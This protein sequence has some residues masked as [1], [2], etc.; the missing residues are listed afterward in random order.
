MRTKPKVTSFELQGMRDSWTIRGLHVMA[1][2]G[3]TVMLT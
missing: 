2:G 3:K 1:E